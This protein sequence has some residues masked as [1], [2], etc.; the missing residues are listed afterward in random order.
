MATLQVSYK[1]LD[2]VHGAL[3]SARSTFTSADLPADGGAFGAEDVSQAFAAFRTSQQRSAAW[4]ADTSRTL[5]Q[6]AHD[7]KSQ[8]ADADLDLARSA[9]TTK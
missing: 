8:V 1:T 4:L 2:Q 6:Y 7:T 3:D 5:A 9:G